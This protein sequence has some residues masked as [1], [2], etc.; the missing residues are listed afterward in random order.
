MPFVFYDTETTGTETAFDQILQFAAIKTDDELNELGEFNIRC[1]L[2]PHVVPSP[3]AL[4]A[5]KVHP[6][7][8]IDP[9]L[10][11]HYEA[12]RAIRGKLIEWSPAIFLGYNSIAF[13]E[14]LLR[15]ALFQTLHPPYLTNTNG[16]ARGDVMRV[17]HAVNLFYPGT[18]EI[19]TDAKG[20]QTFR[21]D[22]LAPANGY[23][24]DDAHEAL[25]DVRATI[26]I[27]RLVRN[28][29]R[30][31]W[32]DLMR[33][34]NKAAVHKMA[35]ERTLLSMAE[36]Y[37]ARTC[38]W[39]VTA[40]GSNPEN[41]GQLAV[42]DLNY[43]P[44]KYL[45]LSVEELIDAL[46]AS[47]K[48]IRTVRANAQPI[49]RS[50]DAAPNIDQIL[51]VSVREAEERASAIRSNQNFQTRVRKALALRYADK[52]PPEHLEQRI[53]DGFPS[54]ADEILMNRFHYA[55]WSDRPSIAEEIKDDRLRQFACRL[56][57]FESPEVM[58]PAKLNELKAWRITRLMSADETVP[59]TTIPRAIR[60]CQELLADPHLPE[61]ALMSDAHRFLY[62]L[63]EGIGRI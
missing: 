3:G 36:R 21:L 6:D 2:L 19:P 50:A 15:Q 4:L 56:L 10:P 52:T 31:V 59:W 25:A 27:A 57:F 41:S 39:I 22:R 40:C 61:R 37:G 20:K 17:A 32:D 34:T 26:F 55:D 24:H 42:F 1:R 7:L 60:E 16:N 46:N 58:A 35:A 51:K 8:L 33:A 44:A 5:T 62:Q 14:D 12:I 9:S 63:A 13:D 23:N 38:S 49:I 53:Y 30:P 43:D 18:L 28:R 54:K 11:S 47:P 45:T 48:V 29:A